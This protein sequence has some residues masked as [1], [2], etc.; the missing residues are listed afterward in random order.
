MKSSK[1]FR[2][3]RR[4]QYRVKQKRFGLVYDSTGHLQVK[5][6][7]L[8]WRQIQLYSLLA[9]TPYGYLSFLLGREILLLKVQADQAYHSFITNV[10]NTVAASYHGSVEDS[11]VADMTENEGMGVFLL[12][13]EAIS[14]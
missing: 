7:S 1:S 13:T 10:L 14:N 6:N 2:T 5:P 9:N 3:K 8:W 11:I 12:T 4:L